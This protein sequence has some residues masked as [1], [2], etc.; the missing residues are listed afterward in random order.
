MVLPGIGGVLVSVCGEFR[1]VR[2]LISFGLPRP[3]V[4]FFRVVL[5]RGSGVF[6]LSVSINDITDPLFDSIT[7][8]RFCLDG[9]LINRPS[10]PRSLIPKLL[11]SWLKS[12]R[13]LLIIFLCNTLP[14]G[15]V[16]VWFVPD[17]AICG[18]NMHFYICFAGVV[19]LRMKK[20]IY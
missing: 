5:S 16:T 8:A 18:L 6:G 1:L 13:G 15:F 19:S 2:S 4:L 10:G 12:E 7:I 20:N 14:V 9:D 11:C 3:Y 17:I